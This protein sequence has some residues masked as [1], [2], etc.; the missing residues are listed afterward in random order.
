MLLSVMSIWKE[1]TNSRNY[2]QS[3][4]PRKIWTFQ[5]YLSQLQKKERKYGT[6]FNVV[7]ICEKE[8]SNEVIFIIPYKYLKEHILPLATQHKGKYYYNISGS[9][10]FNWQHGI[11]M[12]GNRF[13]VR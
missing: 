9:Y 2:F 5:L 10:R 7:V 3:R 8:S 4:S 11:D 12:D 13:R 1:M 6:K